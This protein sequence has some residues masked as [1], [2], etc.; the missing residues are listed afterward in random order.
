MRRFP[1]TISLLV[2]A[3]VV[4]A[5]FTWMVA[6]GERDWYPQALKP[7]LFPGMTPFF[8]VGTLTESGPLA[9]ASFWV[10]TLFVYGICGLVLDVVRLTILSRKR[11]V[12][13]P[14]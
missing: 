6:T 10:G 14:A 5:A 3:I 1:F 4:C 7:L 12:R 8:V 11:R 9:I 2:A 13:S